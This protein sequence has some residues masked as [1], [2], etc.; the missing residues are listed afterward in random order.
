MSKSQKK[1]LK[2]KA[3][4][5]EIVLAEKEVKNRMDVDASTG[6]ELGAPL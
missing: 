3:G 1:K 6:T 2:R 5:E 4:N